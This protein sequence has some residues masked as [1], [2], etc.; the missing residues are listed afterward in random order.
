MNARKY[1]VN[2]N[3][4]PLDFPAI[5]GLGETS[6]SYRSEPPVI[7]NNKVVLT[8]TKAFILTDMSTNKS[9]EV[10]KAQSIY[11]IPV[12]EIKTRDDVYEFYKDSILSLSEAYQYAQK[13][14]PVPNR[15]FPPQP[16]ETY[17]REID[18]VLYLLNSRN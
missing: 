14:L 7:V 11:E 9:H 12:N 16:I 5:I 15:S 3:L 6:V 17:Q 18:G 2:L 1:R 8:I 10:L 13:K 4:S